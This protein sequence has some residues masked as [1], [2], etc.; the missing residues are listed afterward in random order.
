MEPGGSMPRS[1]SLSNNPYPEPNHP[2][3]RQIINPVPRSCVTFLNE[4][5]F[6]S[7]VVSLTPN[8]QA[9]GPLLVGCPRLLIQYIRSLPPYLEA[10][11][12]IRNPGEA[13]CLGERNQ[14]ME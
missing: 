12:A 8:S 4:D 7:E 5:D 10:Y 1:Q 3:T 9:E 13:P 2:I 6:Y 11:S 14:R